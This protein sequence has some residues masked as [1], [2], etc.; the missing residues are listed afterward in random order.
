M[1]VKNIRSIALAFLVSLVVLLLI[2]SPILADLPNPPPRG[3]MEGPPPVRDVRSFK[4]SILTVAEPQP[5]IVDPLAEE[6]IGIISCNNGQGV[7][8]PRNYRARWS[9]SM[10]GPITDE[11]TAG[12]QEATKALRPAQVN[13]ALTYTMQGRAGWERVWT[14][15]GVVYTHIHYRV[16]VV[17]QAVP[18]QNELIGYINVEIPSEYQ[19]RMD[20]KQHAV[21]VTPRIEV[22]L[23]PSE[24]LWQRLWKLIP[25]PTD[26]GLGWFFKYGEI[27]V[28]RGVSIAAAGVLRPGE[29]TTFMLPPG[30]YEAKAAFKIFGIPF[31]MTAASIS[32][33]VPVLLLVTLEVIEVLWYILIILGVVCA[34]LLVWR[35]LEALFGAGKRRRREPPQDSTPSSGTPPGG[36]KTRSGWGWLGALFGAGKRERR[37]PPQ[38]STPSVDKPSGSES[39]RSKWSGLGVPQLSRQKERIFSSEEAE[40]KPG[41]GTTP[42]SDPKTGG[43]TPM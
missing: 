22:P 16:L 15:T 7:L 1:K 23:P 17:R 35:G 18:A 28:H 34:G 36:Q 41:T 26:E 20:E 19:V 32:S 37:E 40:Q 27:K 31:N 2:G 6:V 30:N 14:L 29:T 11:Q 25:K 13:V 21:A 33:E 8:P 9:L 43:G 24:S 3:Q 10:T 42:P 39:T 4:G 38:D 5:D 12:I